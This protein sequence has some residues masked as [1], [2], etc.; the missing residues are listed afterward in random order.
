MIDKNKLLSIS[1]EASS[2]YLGKK[3]SLN[4]T[5]IKAA[6]D[7]K[8]TSEEVQRV[9]EFA[10]TK[11]YLDLVKTSEN[12]YVN[13][14]VADT[15]EI[16]KKAHIEI[17]EE[18]KV[19]PIGN[20]SDYNKPPVKTAS[21]EK[22]AEQKQFVKTA[23]MFYSQ[24]VPSFNKQVSVSTNA[25]SEKSLEYDERI[26]KLAGHVRQLLRGNATD[27]DSIKTL[28]TAVDSS[29]LVWENVKDTLKDEFP[30]IKDASVI[31][32][33][34]VNDSSYLAKEVGSLEKLASAI[35]DNSVVL[36]A[37]ANAFEKESGVF[38]QKVKT[39]AKILGLLTALGLSYTAGQHSQ[40]TKQNLH[41]FEKFKMMGG[42]TQ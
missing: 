9:V 14:D 17:K 3:A 40:N 8:L 22:V 12:R 13:F 42:R 18:P 7:N 35:L 5:I 29:G 36:G 23:S 27:L 16:L 11:T 33:K 37:L 31:E 21:I 38:I 30:M 4:D 34:V 32:G 10:N 25:I 6:M 24:E 15:Q 20:H 1:M 26:N 28:F 19:I 41:E 2:A 39:P